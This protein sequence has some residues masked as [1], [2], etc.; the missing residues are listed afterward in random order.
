MDD[1][2]YITSVTVGYADNGSTVD[3]LRV[4]DGTHLWRYKIAQGQIMDVE[5]ANEMI[6]VSEPHG[7]AALEA[8]NGN[9]RW[10]HADDSVF[11]LTLGV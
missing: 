10:F 2:A 5:A 4:K 9:Q 11:A 7:I 1:V 6:Y 8:R 3:A